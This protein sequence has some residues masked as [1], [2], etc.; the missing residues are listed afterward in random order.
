MMNWTRKL[1]SVLALSLFSAGLVV[2]GN[3]GTAQADVK[4]PITAQLKKVGKGA[5]G[6]KTSLDGKFERYLVS[7]Q[8]EVLGL[9]LQD[10]SEVR[11]PPGANTV[12]TLQKGDALH[13]EGHQKAFA[14]GTVY[15]HA[16]VTKG[17]TVVADG[18]KW[19]KGEKGEKG[20]KKNGEKPKLAPMTLTST[21]NG[22]VLDAK[23]RHVGLLLADGS[24][25]FAHD[26]LMSLGVKKG[27]SVTIEGHGGSYDLG[28]SVHVK[29]IKLPDGKVVTPKK[30]EKKT[31]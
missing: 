17:N 9:L 31:K 3:A 10:G 16:L 29:S 25:A 13:V 2:G 20:E 26:D 18:S 15:V 23:G 8:G 24:E 1:A 11:V 6:K 19:K 22:F 12:K 4:A 14:D 21:V 28:R 5:K 7:P 30:H 27:D